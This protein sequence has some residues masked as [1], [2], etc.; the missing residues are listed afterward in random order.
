[1]EII[2]M[3]KNYN[4][5]FAG[6]LLVSLFVAIPLFTV[7]LSF[8]NSTSEYYDLLRNTFLKNYITNSFIILIGVLSLTFGSIHISKLGSVGEVISSRP[9]NIEAFK[10]R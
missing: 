6:S 1:M 3:Y 10:K 4:F 5:W 8:F 9:L 2:K 7:F